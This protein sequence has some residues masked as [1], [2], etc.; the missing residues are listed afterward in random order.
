MSSNIKTMLRLSAVFSLLWM[1]QAGADQDL[2]TFESGRLGLGGRVATMGMSGISRPN[3]PQIHAL[4]MTIGTYRE[5]IPPLNGVKYDAETA[6]Q[7]ARRMGVMDN[8]I[9]TLRDDEL[10]LEG[11][12]KAFDELESRVL[13]DDQV[14]IYYSGHGGRQL[15]REEGQFE[16]CAES[17]ITV[18]GRGFIDSELEVRLKQLSQKAQKLIVL[19]DAC[20]SGGVTTRAVGASAAA[21]KFTPKYW[22][23]KGSGDACAKPANVVTRGIRA[24]T[25][26]VGSG[27]NNYVYIAAARDDE[28][29]FDQPGKGGVAS[30][31]WLD[32]MNGAAQDLDGSGG[33]SAEEIRACAQEKIDQK[34]S[35][36]VGLLPP[37]VSVTGN[38]RTVLGFPSGGP[39]AEASTAAG[40]TASTPAALSAASLALTASPTMIE[41]PASPAR[42]NP[43]ATL[44]DIYGN[45][46]DR[47]L[48]EL[49]TT[50]HRLKIGLDNLEFTLTSSHE[51][52][53]YLL[54]VGSD[55]T[56]FDLLFP[57]QQDR[58]NLIRAG[59]TLKLPRSTWQL[60]VQGPPGKDRLLAIVA[61]SP[62]D[63]SRLGMKPAGPFSVIDTRSA[64]FRPGDVQVV[65][66][67]PS[68]AGVGDCLMERTRN[69]AVQK[70]CSSAYGAALLVVEEVD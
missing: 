58:N 69:L 18:D 67:S 16:R 55:G 37:H 59:E 57:N 39:V 21:A 15:V 8:N 47:R 40:G 1:A 27:A 22:Q 24:G 9:R 41:S 11:M 64:A 60:T 38:S 65:S 44:E 52:H 4:I 23:G 20:H 2:P 68:N 35:N 13:Q 43:A 32:C 17:L 42:P 53:V 66:G 61:E 28:I 7:I 54:M 25:R 12:S 62:R 19:I 14:F 5:G 33:L 56:T 51:G 31:A 29:S 70:S 48:V 30:Q 34:M 63:F 26:S 46:D 49:K 50:R 36:A 10:T 6:R 45:R 3:S